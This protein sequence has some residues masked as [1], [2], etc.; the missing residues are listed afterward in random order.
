MKKCLQR[1]LTTVLLLTLERTR[2]GKAPTPPPHKVF[3]EFFRDEL[4]S[5]P[6]VFSS[7][8]YI[9]YTRFNARLVSIG[10]YGYE[11]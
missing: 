6:A 7:C 1:L 5:S 10:C 9:P 11:I 4:S 8:V 2:G 3:L